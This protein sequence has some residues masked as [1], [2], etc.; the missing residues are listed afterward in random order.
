MQNRIGLI[1]ISALLS[2]TAAVA[3]Q[4]PS[5]ITPPIAPAEKV[6]PQS[7]SSSGS[8]AVTVKPDD[9]MASRLI[10]ATIRTPTNESIGDINDLVIDSSGEIKAVIAGIGGFLGLGEHKVL[11]RFDQVQFNRDSNGKLFV[12]SQ[13][14]KEQLRALPAWSDADVVKAK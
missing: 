5:T 4:A 12:V 3:Q 6:M 2:S 14:T 11:L 10:G 13:M 7:K 9:R 8:E 1:V